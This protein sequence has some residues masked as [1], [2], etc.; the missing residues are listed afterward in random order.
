MI[1]IDIINT[2]LTHSK[3]RASGDDPTGRPANTEPPF[4]NP[5]RAGM[6]PARPAS[7]TDGRCKPRAS[8]DDPRHRHLDRRCGL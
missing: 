4:V 1:R 7:S 8:G 6:I 5:A 3:P 2:A